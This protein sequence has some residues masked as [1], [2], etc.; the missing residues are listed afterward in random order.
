MRVIEPT[1]DSLVAA[2]EKGAGRSRLLPANAGRASTAVRAANVEALGLAVCSIVML[3]GLW[4]TTV[5]RVEQL[6][7]AT[8]STPV[9]NLRTLRSPEDLL[10]LLTMFEDRIERQAAAR[11]LYR[12]AV[13]DD[14]PLDHVGGLSAATISAEEIR[15]NP[16]YV[17]LRA[18]LSRR[19]GATQAQVLA[20]ADLAALKPHVVVRTLRD[21]ARAVMRA[22][23]LFL[24]AFWFA[25]IV[26]RW[27][28]AEDDPLMLPILLL[29]SGIGLMSMLALRDP[30]RD[31]IP[32]EVFAT[33]VAIG[34]ALL[35]AA[36]E[37]DFEASRLRRAVV[38]PLG[39]ALG[40]ASLLLVFGNGP[41]SSGAKVNL[42]G[43][44]P[45]EVIRLLVVFALAAY[46]ARRLEHLREL[47]ESPTAARPWLKHINLPRW[48]D[49][50]PVVVSMLVVLAFFFLQKDLGPALVLTCVV[51]ALY[52]IARGR[53]GSV[54]LGQAMFVAG[55]SVAYVIGVPAT[56]RQRVLI[57]LNPWNN[58]VP[59]GNQI[60]YGLWA[61]A[62]GAVRGS[63]PGLGTPQSI[64]AGHT[65][66]VLA[67][68]GEQLGFVGLAVVFAL[69]AM[70]TWRCLRAAVRAPGD[71]SA[72]LATG[73]ALAL[74]VQALVIASGLLGLFP[75][76]GV[77]TPFLSY[78]RSSMIANG[79][80]VGVVMAVAR[81]QGAVRP[82]FE[83]PIRT[84][85][86]V[87]SI[88]AIA[89]LTR[90]GWVQ[91]VKADA[92]ATAASL[93]EQA[94]GGYRFE[95]NPRLVAAA[96]RL[97][98]G[99][100][101]DRNG[102][103]LATS[104]PVE[105]RALDAGYQKAGIA[106]DQ[107]CASRDARCYPLGGLLFSV[108][109]DWQHQTNWGARNSSYI[110]RDS[111][112]QLKGFDDRQRVV[113]VVNPR[114]GARDRTIKR[115]Y[116]ELLPLVRYGTDSTD[117]RV[118]ALMT[119]SRDVRVS[120]DAR[121][122]TRA[123]SA[124][125]R[126]IAAGG[127][128]RGAAIVLDVET[129]DLL[130]SVSYPWPTTR[131]DTRDDDPV[132]ES[133]IDAYLDRSRYGL[134]PP[135]STFKLLVASAALRGNP[136]AENEAFTCLRL[137]DG[138]VG[139][140][141]RGWSRPV[142]DDPL[143]TSPHGRVTLRR[144]LVVSCNAYF[145]QLALRLG[146]RPILDAA[147]FFQID[148]ARPDTAAALRR[149]LPYAG[150]GQAD[151][152]VSPLKMA[153]VAAA[154]A[155]GGRVLPVRWVTDPSSAASEPAARFLPPAA[156]RELSEYMR[157]VVTSGTGRIL[158]SNSTPI[159]GKTGTAEVDGARAHSWFAGFAPA[160]GSHPIAFAVIVENA[161]YGARAAASIAG[162]IVNAAREIGFL[163]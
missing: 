73:A 97:E 153:R 45:V 56:V 12:Q 32:A 137:R 22:C 152:L 57:W 98:R 23:G 62:T 14:P 110:E 158:L 36:A 91:I 145:A 42:L 135:G 96:A 84:L 162:E 104:R 58:G 114:T 37:F 60:A 70:L 31:T 44:Q 103:V 25:H 89:V 88:A 147:S 40:L 39:L 3:F 93:T 20:A 5:G 141:L 134:Y 139:N 72:L 75:L 74:V 63:G 143:D 83:A 102:L 128:A 18:R 122:Q 157:E 85:A 144:G 109:G 80:A 77:V 1:S 66:F 120:I 48:I 78:G 133:A 81:R 148:T 49:V 21:Y 68:I 71:F 123:A 154:V 13:S 116:S 107:P 130:A 111:D 82:H 95:Y 117:P 69:Y 8:D 129:G 155:A 29:L 47:S 79:F 156:A 150:Y 61:M 19:P 46:F 38:G 146:P 92:F 30:V 94:D 118:R 142:R 100:I 34:L 127:Y 121:L 41:G 53:G 119:R 59:G 55:F 6:K 106:I 99:S 54:V 115:D 7:A 9:L 131:E 113:D 27:R 124:L 163:K 136:A 15:R 4:L 10:P 51:L 87:L 43:F 151:V 33:G 26:R 101:Y 24:A 112:A 64:P 17:E 140:Y 2:V 76:S 28:R 35:V 90:A 160:G 132:G 65:D 67:A 86:A 125:R 161:G 11:M 108:L 126:G 159:A 105:V 138:R 149:T 16:H 52:A 50:R